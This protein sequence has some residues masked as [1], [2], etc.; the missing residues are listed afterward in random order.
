MTTMR[1]SANFM[2]GLSLLCLVAAGMTW[3]IGDTLIELGYWKVESIPPRAAYVATPIDPT[4]TMVPF[5]GTPLPSATVS[6][7]NLTSL[8]ICESE[9]RRYSCDH[10][11]Q[12]GMFGQK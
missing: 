5:V 11:S 1:D 9:V 6:P 2:I 8:V 3:V 7:E 10:E 4:P 12:I